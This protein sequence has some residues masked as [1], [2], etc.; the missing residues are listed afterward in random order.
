MVPNG[1]T[2]LAK[3]SK[4]LFLRILPGLRCDGGPGGSPPSGGTSV[5]QMGESEISHVVVVQRDD[6]L[7]LDDPSGTGLGAP[8]ALL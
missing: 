7:R 8:A 4:S 2:Q 6:L 3:V 1:R 5:W